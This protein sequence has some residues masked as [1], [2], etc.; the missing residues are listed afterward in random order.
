[1]HERRFKAEL[2][3]TFIH[4]VH[5]FMRENVGRIYQSHI[6][7]KET[8]TIY[9]RNL[10]FTPFFNDLVSNFLQLVPNKRRDSLP[11]RGL[12]LFWYGIR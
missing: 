12:T 7:K 6:K 1:M 8:I 9:I 11:F 5:R 2:S 3:N 4:D 10:D